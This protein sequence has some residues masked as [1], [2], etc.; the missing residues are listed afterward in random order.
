MVTMPKKAFLVAG[1]LLVLGV[2][3]WLLRPVVDDGL[4]QFPHAF[5]PQ[6]EATYDPHAVII[7]L[8][9]LESPPSLD[10]YEPAWVCSDRA[11][12][13][14]NGRPWIFALSGSSGPV[15]PRLKRVPPTD[16]MHPFWTPEAE[17]MLAEYSHRFKGGE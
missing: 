5:L 3:Y 15:H 8:A 7:H 2:G 9:P 6:G 10:G 16:Q 12:D 11:F 13:D 1:V 14:V 4:S 17:R